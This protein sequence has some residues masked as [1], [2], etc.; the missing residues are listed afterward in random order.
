VKITNPNCSTCHLGQRRASEVQIPDIILICIHPAAA[1]GSGLLQTVPDCRYGGVELRGQLFNG[2]ADKIQLPDL[3]VIYLTVI[4]PASTLPGWFL[5][6]NRLGRRMR[7][8]LG[9]RLR[10]ACGIPGFRRRAAACLPQRQERVVTG[11]GDLTVKRAQPVDLL[12]SRLA[13]VCDTVYGQLAVVPR[14]HRVARTKVP[15]LDWTLN[16]L[17]TH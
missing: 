12:V 2:C 4:T 9:I 5:P 6:W 17:N 14:I 15:D 8:S 13:E 10:P 7:D 1:R 16:C 3:S 11:C